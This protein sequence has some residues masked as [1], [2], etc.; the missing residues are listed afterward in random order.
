M[1]SFLLILIVLYYILLSY[2]KKKP[3]KEAILKQNEMPIIENEQDCG[4]NFLVQFSTR[5]KNRII[6]KRFGI[7]TGKYGKS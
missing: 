6:Y 1:A 2:C 7:S 3:K 5:P 4:S